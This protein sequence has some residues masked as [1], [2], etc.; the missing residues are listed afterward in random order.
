[1]WQATN[2]VKLDGGWITV[3]EEKSKREEAMEE[4]E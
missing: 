2:G 1:M 3:T 4:V